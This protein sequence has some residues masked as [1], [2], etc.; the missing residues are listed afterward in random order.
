MK[1]KSSQVLAYG[2]YTPIEPAR[3]VAG[4][5]DQI[6]AYCE[7]ENFA[8]QLNPDKQWE[9]RLK[10]DVVIYSDQGLELWSANKSEKNS[11][12]LVVDRSRNRRH[13]FFVI[14]RFRLPKTLVI[15]RYIM[16]V[17]VVDQEVNRIAENSLPLEIVAQ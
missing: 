15:G 5:N 11:S 7:V 17:T 4:F 6:C 12:G 3:F 13:D 1:K 10:M 9:T 8:S 14:Q 2:V 16:K